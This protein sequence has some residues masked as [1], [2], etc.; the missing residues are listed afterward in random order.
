M[1]LVYTVRHF[2]RRRLVVLVVKGTRVV[3]MWA[4]AA[5]L[6]MVWGEKGDCYRV[7]RSPIQ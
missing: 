2:I 5:L 6:E 3:G 4:Q 1:V 7:T